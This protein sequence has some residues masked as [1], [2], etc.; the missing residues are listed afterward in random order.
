MESNLVATHAFELIPFLKNISVGLVGLFLS[1]YANTF[2]LRRIAISYEIKAR[3][4]L[5][6]E[7][8]SGV[9]FYYFIAI[10]NLMM[11]QILAIILWGAILFFFSLINDPLSA[12]IFAGSCYTTIGI[13]SDVMPTGWHFMSILIAL[14]GLFA[15]AMATASMLNMTTLFRRAW[16]MKHA[17]RIQAAMDRDK[18]IIPDFVSLK[19]TI[20]VHTE[21]KT[22]ISTEEHR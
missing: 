8:P 2:F 12:V 16:L 11:V 6:K 22:E 14:S 9:F 15:V 18:I 1:L 3:I 5:N 19:E 17:D 4:Y 13:V 21:I 7:N 20:N 10:I